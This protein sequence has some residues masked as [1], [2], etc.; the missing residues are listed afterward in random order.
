MFVFELLALFARLSRP[1][2]SPHAASDNTDV[3]I[4]ER[5]MNLFICFPLRCV[6]N[7]KKR[8]YPLDGL[9][10][11]VIVS[12]FLLWGRPQCYTQNVNEVNEKVSVRYADQPRV[13]LSL[14]DL[15]VDVKNLVRN[16]MRKI[17]MAGERINNGS[18][19]RLPRSFAA[20][21]IFPRLGAGS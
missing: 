7:F 4:N 11:P 9:S 2:E 18:R 13:G 15:H 3:I 6:G 21:S 5:K 8:P 10:S 19:C 20:A 17:T 1:H 16:T 14:V 12:G